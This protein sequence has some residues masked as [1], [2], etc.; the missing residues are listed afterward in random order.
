M[1]THIN[2]NTMHMDEY[3]LKQH[4]EIKKFVMWKNIYTAMMDFCSK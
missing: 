3:K 4:C 2:M 1:N